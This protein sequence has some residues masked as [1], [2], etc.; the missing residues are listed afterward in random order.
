MARAET[1][2]AGP[3]D[4]LPPDTERYHQVVRVTHWLMALCFLFMWLSG[5][6]MRNLMQ[7]NSPLQEYVYDLHKSVGVTLIPLLALRLSARLLAPVPALPKAVPPV[8]RRAAKLGHLGIYGLIILG[9]ITGWMLTDFGGH[10]VIWFGL[11][12]PQVFPI[13]E[14]LFGVE[15]DPLTSDVH[16]WLVYTLL[17]LITIHVAAVLKHRV[18]DGIDLLPRI[19]LRPI[20]SSRVEGARS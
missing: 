2:H 9:L 20:K 4:A 7:H 1:I 11:A 8:E 15:L 13:R 14:Q 10:G 12:M 3:T 17:A 5:F 16:K 18:K 6:V 19:G